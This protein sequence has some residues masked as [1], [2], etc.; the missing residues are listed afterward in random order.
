MKPPILG[1]IA[2]VVGLAAGTGAKVMTTHPAPA[3]AD[4]TKADSTKTDSLKSEGGDSTHAVQQAGAA[5]AMTDTA[6]VASGAS[7][8]APIEVGAA[9]ALPTQQK[10]T[11]QKPVVATK[12][13]AAAFAAALEARVDSAKKAAE[14]APPA[15][16]V[17]DTAAIA[18]QKRVAKIFTSMDA[19]AAA[20]VLV[21][22]SDNDIH[23]ILGYVGPKQA[24]QIMTELPPERVAK[25]SKLEMG[26]K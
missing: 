6:V 26:G 21:Q 17:V 16:V 2:L 10:P 3:V 14:K 13:N 25:L 22:M 19:K 24:A 11:A 12:S 8:K 15:P 23:V 7:E 4:S 18:A 20:K 5:Q 1:A 9:S